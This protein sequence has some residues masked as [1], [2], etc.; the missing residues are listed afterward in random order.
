MK[1]LKITNDHG[2]TPRKLRKKERIIKN[3]SFRQRVIAVRLVMEGYLGKDVAAMVN[4]CR[5]TVAFYVSLFNEGELDLLLD[6]KL[7]PGREPF[8]TDEQQQA[9]KQTILTKT[10]AELGW[11]IASSWNTKIVQSYTQ[12]QYGVSMSREDVRKLLHRMNLSWTRPT[13]TLAKG[14][15]DKQAL[16]EQEM[17]FIKKLVD[18]RTLLFYVDETHVRSYQVLCATWSGVGK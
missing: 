10:P 4:L 6:R 15:A 5:Q 17:E 1:R 3:A 14:D 2:W 11:G 12:Q 9:L 8:L 18:S 13:Y 16:F 7:P